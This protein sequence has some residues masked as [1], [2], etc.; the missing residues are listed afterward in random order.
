MKNDTNAP[1]ESDNRQPSEVASPAPRSVGE[2]METI[3]KALESLNIHIKKHGLPAAVKLDEKWIALCEKPFPLSEGNIADEEIQLFSIAHE[4]NGR[5][6]DIYRDEMNRAVTITIS[7]QNVTTEA[8][9]N[10]GTSQRRHATNE[11]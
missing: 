9:H 7:S 6:V 4:I 5:R 8:H 11:H 10:G 2:A 1:T 3:R